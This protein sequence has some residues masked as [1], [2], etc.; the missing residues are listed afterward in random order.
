MKA[1]VLTKGGETTGGTQ[2]R[3]TGS[4]PLDERLGGEPLDGR[5]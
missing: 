2:E 1:G 4:L 3:T 5:L